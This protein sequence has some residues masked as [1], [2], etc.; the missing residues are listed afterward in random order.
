[1]VN[2]NKLDKKALEFYKEGRAKKQTNSPQDDK[3][4]QGGESDG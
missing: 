2:E 4:M 3:D 1:M